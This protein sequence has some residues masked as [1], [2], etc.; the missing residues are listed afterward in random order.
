M[1]NLITYDE[2]PELIAEYSELLQKE[3]PEVT[4]FVN[5][6]TTS[7]AQVALADNFNTIFGKGFIEEKIGNYK[8]KITPNSFFQTN[9]K[10]CEKLFCKR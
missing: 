2:N 7:K 9:S 8:L 5:S 10:Q 6:L 3:V 4:T 1:V